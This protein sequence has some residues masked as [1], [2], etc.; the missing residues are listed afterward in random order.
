MQAIAAKHTPEGALEEEVAALLAAAGAASTAAV[1]EAE[2]KLALKQVFWGS[3]G[4][5]VKGDVVLK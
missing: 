1:A 4:V 2:E 5:N 3:G